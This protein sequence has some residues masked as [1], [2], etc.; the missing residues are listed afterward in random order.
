M[1]AALPLP[2]SLP[3]WAGQALDRILR[4]CPRPLDRLWADP[5]LVMRAAGLTPDPWQA[6]LLASAADRVLLCCSR[7]SGKTRTVAALAL[8]EALLVDDATCLI[9][10]PSER[11]SGEF[12][13]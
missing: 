10:S 4:N 11:Q 2:R 12:L 1:S 9:V 6:G 8:R 5:T 13:A 3:P 7:Q